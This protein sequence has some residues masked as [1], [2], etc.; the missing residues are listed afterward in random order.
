MR[1]RKRSIMTKDKRPSILN[2]SRSNGSN[3]FIYCNALSL[4][5]E[6][7]VNYTTYNYVMYFNHD[8][9]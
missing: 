7:D 3:E 8:V 4:F 5:I 6:F 1:S 2:L 9:F